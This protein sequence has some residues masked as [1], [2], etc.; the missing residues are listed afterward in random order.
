MTPNL[1]ILPSPIALSYRRIRACHNKDARRL[2]HILQTAEMSAR[3]L[4]VIILSDIREQVKKG[5]LAFPPPLKKPLENLRRPSFGHWIEIIREGM[6]AL[7]ENK[8]PFIPELRDFVF[9]GSIGSPSKSFQLLNDIVAIRNRFAHGNMPL[10]EIARTCDQAEKMVE[11]IL[12]GL[13][14]FEEYN[15]YYVKQINIRKRR[16]TVCSYTHQFCLL[17][18]PHAPPDAVVEE[19]DWHTDT[20]E[21]ILHKNDNTY[22]NLS[23]FVIYLDSEHY[24]QSMGIMPDI[25][26]FNGYEKKGPRLNMFFVP[27][28]PGSKDIESINLPDEFEQDILSEGL[29][30][31]YEYAGE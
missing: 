27:C 25:Y 17:S 6:R 16:L 4:S 21:L 20:D 15:L 22:L 13:S 19:R 11:D 23:P 14:F 1:E 3:L 10:P 29:K 31:Y 30:E 7:A 28:G 24:D 5:L 26:I 18:G 2:A 9:S 12:A 8:S